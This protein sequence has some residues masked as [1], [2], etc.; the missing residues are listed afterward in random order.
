MSVKITDEYV[1]GWTAPIDYELK[2]TNEATRRLE[3]FDA[4][5]STIELVLV[6]RDGATVSTSGKVSW[7]DAPNSIARYTPTAGDLLAA[8]SPYRARWRVTDS[9]AIATY[10]KGEAIQWTVR[11][12]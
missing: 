9:G 2:R 3:T 8:K 6:D 7:I 1:Q 11:T 4:T 12:P 5:G 10:P